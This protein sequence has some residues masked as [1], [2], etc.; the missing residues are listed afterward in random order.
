MNIDLMMFQADN[1]TIFVPKL[2]KQSRPGHDRDPMVFLRYPDQEI[3]VVSHL[4]QYIEKIKDLQ[5]D[6]NL[7]KSFVKLH[8]RTTTSTISRSC[9]TVLKN[10]GVD[11][12]VFESHS[13]RSALTAHCKKKELSMK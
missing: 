2:L 6:Q 5:K 7:L 11:I 4:E 12:T 8:K 1:V 3:Y 9:A 10:A 13:T